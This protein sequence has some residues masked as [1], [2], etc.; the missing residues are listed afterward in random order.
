[1]KIGSGS[2]FLLVSPSV[3]RGWQI[4]GELLPG[5]G[6]VS[7]KESLFFIFTPLQRSL[8]CYQYFRWHILLLRWILCKG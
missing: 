7:R 3:T 1:M 2:L 8:R 6:L 5:E 4:F